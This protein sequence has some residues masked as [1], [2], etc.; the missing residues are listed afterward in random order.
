MTNE[1]EPVVRRLDDGSMRLLGEPSPGQW[2]R[3]KVVVPPLQWSPR[4]GMTRYEWARRHT[5][6]SQLPFWKEFQRAR[7]ECKL[8][9]IDPATLDRKVVT[10]PTGLQ[11]TSPETLKQI[12]DKMVYRRSPDG[13]WSFRIACEVTQEPWKGAAD[14]L[15]CACLDFRTLPDWELVMRF[16]SWA[17]DDD[18][19]CFLWMPGHDENTLG[20]YMNERPNAVTM[21][22]PRYIKPET[23][24]CKF[25]HE[26][27]PA[28]TAHPHQGA[29]VGDE[30]C[31]DERLKATE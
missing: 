14:I 17:L 20:R 29:W 21:M 10:M 24:V 4:T 5:P 27:V 8:D 9:L 25:C 3:P 13:M 19:D 11:G 22:A 16:R 30:C 31:W 12:I 15:V 23:V 1:K 6:E 18:R 26:Q 28:D 2:H 7:L